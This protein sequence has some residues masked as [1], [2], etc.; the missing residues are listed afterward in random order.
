MTWRL[1]F[2]RNFLLICIF[3]CILD[4]TFRLP[5]QTQDQLTVVSAANYQSSVSPGSLATVFGSSLASVTG[6]AQL[7]SSG[8]LPL[9][10]G[11]T[12]VTIDGQP[13]S[14]IYVSPG[15]LNL[16]IPDGIQAGTVPIVVTSL[17]G[18]SQGTAVIR[19]I[20][21]GLFSSDGSGKGAGSIL[22]GVT[23]T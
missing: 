5:A 20:A 18:R 9:Q 3:V 8:K 12:S 17:N 22:N 10:I 6:S 13:A 2:F 14:L 11:G 4:A 23:Y 16:V 1:P 19:T 7:D 15:Q 21:P